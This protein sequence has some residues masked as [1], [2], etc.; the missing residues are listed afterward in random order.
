MVSYRGPQN[1]LQQRARCTSVIS[2]NFEYHTGGSMVWLGSIPI[3]KENTLEVTRGEG[4]SH[5]Y[6][7]SINLTRGFAAGWLLMQ[8]MHYTYKHPSLLQD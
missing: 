1:S 3:S 6:S 2:L 4:V 5:I 7:T 8:H